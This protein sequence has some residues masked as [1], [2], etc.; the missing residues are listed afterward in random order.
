MY[1]QG[2]NNVI[3]SDVTLTTKSAILIFYLCLSRKLS[4][5]PT[6]PIFW[7]Q[8]FANN[9]SDKV[10]SKFLMSD[11][12]LSALVVQAVMFFTISRN[13]IFQKNSN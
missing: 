12:E 2:E 3:H 4:I 6:G 10:T 8:S 13:F 5:M 1:S 11:H 7:P 9:D